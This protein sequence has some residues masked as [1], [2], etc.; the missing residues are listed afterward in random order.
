M[1]R[2][3]AQCDSCRRTRSESTACA[4]VWFSDNKIHETH[5]LRKTRTQFSQAKN[6]TI[7]R[8]ASN[9][10]RD[11][12]RSTCCGHLAV[13]L[14]VHFFII[15]HRNSH[16][17]LFL[18]SRSLD[19]PSCALHTG[20]HSFRIPLWLSLHDTPR[21]TLLRPIPC[22][23]HWFVG[24]PFASSFGS[25]PRLFLV[26]PVPFHHGPPKKSAPPLSA[27]QNRNQWPPDENTLVETGKRI[28]ASTYGGKAR[29]ITSETHWRA[30]KIRCAS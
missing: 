16:L 2:R 18:D 7:H 12:L 14:L 28:L 22:W 13:S 19:A 29:R 4:R 21:W 23:I 10:D 17:R 5:T 26:P 15:V 27:P 24:L 3:E 11:C 9:S 30:K 8:S 25:S 20:S 1:E 6:R